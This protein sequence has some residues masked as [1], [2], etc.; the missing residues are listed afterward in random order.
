LRI[1]AISAALCILRETHPHLELPDGL[2][3]DCK[4]SDP[5]TVTA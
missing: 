1:P 5:L 4:H 2:Q 3:A